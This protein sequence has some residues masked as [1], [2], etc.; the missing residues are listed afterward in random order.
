[1]HLGG[2]E[3]GLDGQRRHLTRARAEPRRETPRI[4]TPR[5]ALPLLPLLV[6][7]GLPRR[8]KRGQ[9]GGGARAADE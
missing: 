1:M 9:P 3:A 7:V 8:H 4:N 6:Q 2:D 5:A